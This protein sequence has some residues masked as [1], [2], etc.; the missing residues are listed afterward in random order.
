MAFCAAIATVSLNAQLTPFDDD[1]ESY[2]PVLDYSPINAGVWL[3]F[4]SNLGLDG[5]TFMGGGGGDALNFPET[6]I[7]SIQTAGVA[8]NGGAQYM[9]VA[10][11]YFDGNHAGSGNYIETR[12]LR[13]FVLTAADLD[14]DF[15]FSFDSET[16]S[17]T[18]ITDAN[19]QTVEAFVRLANNNF[20]DITDF[21]FNTQGVTSWTT[22][23]IAFS[24]D[25]S[26]PSVGV[27][28]VV[29][30]GFLSRVRN[31]GESFV[32][33]DNVSLSLAPVVVSNEPIPT[34]GE[35]G[36]IILGLS[37]VLIGLVYMRSVT[38]VLAK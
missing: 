5:A 14:Q 12:V 36:L 38:A 29:Q 2:S 7:S 19:T 27:G 11:N 28:S 4:S 24:T 26:L 13:E 1:F 25:S 31:G 17:G 16:T 15:I 37:I 10:N 20:A 8:P 21:A 18:A 22:N 3:T 23:S 6:F 34:L 35:W 32:N 33:Y 9:R 30:V